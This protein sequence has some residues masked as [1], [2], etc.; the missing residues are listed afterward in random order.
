M[1]ELKEQILASRIEFLNKKSR[2]SAE[3]NGHLIPRIS[4]AL[5]LNRMDLLKEQLMITLGSLEDL[6]ELNNEGDLS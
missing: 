6:S 3:I 1:N 2:I 4:N 5:N